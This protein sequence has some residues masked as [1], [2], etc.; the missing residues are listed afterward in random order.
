MGMANARGHRGQLLVLHRL[1]EPFPI[2]ERLR[3]ERLAAR[4]SQAE[5]ARRL[6]KTQAWVSLRESGQ[7]VVPAQ[8]LPAYAAALG[9]TVSRL[10]NESFRA[11][12]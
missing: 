11:A 2:H 4:I 12:G 9:V 1:P 5:L 10:Y 8:L 7:R 6:G 3:D